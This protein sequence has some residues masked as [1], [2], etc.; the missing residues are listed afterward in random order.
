MFILF[1]CFFH[2]SSPFRSLVIFSAPSP[3][4]GKSFF[5]HWM[6][7]NSLWCRAIGVPLVDTYRL[8]HSKHSRTRTLS[9]SEFRIQLVAMRACRCS[10]ADDWKEILEGFLPHGHMR[11]VST[12]DS[13]CAGGQTRRSR[14]ISGSFSRVNT[15]RTHFLVDTSPSH[16]GLHSLPSFV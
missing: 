4:L 5:T 10:K 14:K 12:S 6:H 1:P 7:A 9:I 2:I 11:A 16:Y 3:N 15:R 13:H 8:Q